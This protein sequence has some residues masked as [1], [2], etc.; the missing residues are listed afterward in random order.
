MLIHTVLMT[1]S[2]SLLQPPPTPTPS[3]PSPG[4]PRSSSPSHVPL[5]HTLIHTLPRLPVLLC[6]PRPPPS[7][8]SS[9]VLPSLPQSQPPPASLTSL[10]AV[11]IY[12]FIVH[13]LFVLSQLVHHAV[14][15]LCLRLLQFTPPLPAST[16]LH[17]GLH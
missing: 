4:L 12:L 7:P 13:T 10:P 6:P 9:P 5:I 1:C 8:P 17:L 2:P 16:R 11:D 3:L 15:I 14:I